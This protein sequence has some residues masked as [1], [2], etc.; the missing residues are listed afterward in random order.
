MVLDHFLLG[1]VAM[2]CFVAG[3]FFLRFWK[4]SGDRLFV[5]F[6]LA[7]WILGITRVILVL[8][9]SPNEAPAYLYLMRLFAYVLILVSIID[10]NLKTQNTP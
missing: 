5:F 4:E 10:K 1:A 2:A 6:A 8:M 9:E 3:L 7:F